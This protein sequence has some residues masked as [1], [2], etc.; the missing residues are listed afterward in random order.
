[1]PSFKF[2]RIVIDQI[3]LM[4]L[5]VTPARIV[6][7]TATSRAIAISARVLLAP[8]SERP[9]RR[10][11]FR[12]PIRGIDSQYPLLSSSEQNVAAP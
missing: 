7:S 8:E 1:M 11:A 6:S 12:N 10:G 5:T 2:H 4:A 9:P 3:S